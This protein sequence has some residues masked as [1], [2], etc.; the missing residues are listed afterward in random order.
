MP[1]QNN[2]KSG[3]TL[4][5]GIEGKNWEVSVSQEYWN[6]N[7]SNDIG[8]NLTDSQ[9]RKAIASVHFPP[10][11]SHNQVSNTENGYTTQES[12]P[13]VWNR[14][15]IPN[16]THVIASGLSSFTRSASYMYNSSRLNSG[17]LFRGDGCT[18]QQSCRICS[19]VGDPSMEPV[20]EHRQNSTGFPD[21]TDILLERADTWQDRLSP[22]TL[23][24]AP[25]PFQP[26]DWKSFKPEFTKPYTYS[27]F[28][29]TTQK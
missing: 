27:Y 2:H 24:K 25:G 10:I 3:V 23:T 13:T 20:L 7:N 17:R 5:R 26:K 29:N 16:H 21:M 8:I 6:E 18:S 11:R 1:P 19:G 12:H 9:S 4:K 22:G 14:S 15:Q 28:S